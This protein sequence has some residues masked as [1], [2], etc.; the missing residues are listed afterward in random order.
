MNY[1]AEI[2]S[3][4]ISRNNEGRA[5]VLRKREFLYDCFRSR[6]GGK[7]EREGGEE[8]AEEGMA[9]VNFSAIPL[10]TATI[11]LRGR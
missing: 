5:C 2:T 6:G 10:I 3:R 1:F 9:R 11:Y 8:L 4:I 7:R